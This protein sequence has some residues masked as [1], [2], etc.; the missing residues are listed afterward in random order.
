MTSLGENPLAYINNILS[1][2]YIYL[3][4]KAVAILLIVL[5]IIMIYFSY[6]AGIYPPGITGIGFIAIALVFLKE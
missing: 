5:G 6:K 1:I 4:K 3:M 2:Q